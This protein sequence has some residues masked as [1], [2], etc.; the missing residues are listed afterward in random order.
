VP[1]CSRFILLSRVEAHGTVIPE[2]ERDEVGPAADRAVLGESLAASPARVHQ[3]VV[4]L[5]AE[6]ATV[7][8]DP[9]S[10]RYHALQEGTPRVS[11]ENMARLGFRGDT[12]HSLR[13]TK[14]TCGR[15]ISEP[16]SCS[17]DIQSSRAP[18]YLGIEVDD[19]LEVSEQ[20]E[21]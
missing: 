21:V 17:W 5:A 2:G 8:H 12:T 20:T 15:R 11:S 14:A 3:N 7:R 4:V 16:S 10:T 19:A 18:S 13:R 6:R 1:R 9:H